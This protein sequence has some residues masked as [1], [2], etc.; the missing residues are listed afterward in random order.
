MFG[1]LV[2]VKNSKVVSVTYGLKLQ[3]IPNECD[4]INHAKKEKQSV[5]RQPWMNGK[6]EIVLDIS[7]LFVF[8]LISIM[9]NS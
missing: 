1:E 8:C 4:L 6:H 3:G 7:I 2:M 5:S 9:V